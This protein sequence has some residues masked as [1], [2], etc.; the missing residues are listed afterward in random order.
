MFVLAEVVDSIGEDHGDDPEFVGEFVEASCP[1]LGGDEGF[2]GDE[3]AGGFDADVDFGGRGLAFGMAAVK[4]YQFVGEDAAPL[5]LLEAFVHPDRVDAVGPSRRV[6][7]HGDQV[8]VDVAESPKFAPWV[9]HATDC[10]GRCRQY[11]LCGGQ[12]LVADKGV[13]SSESSIKATVCR[14]YSDLV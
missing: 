13:G 12:K 1:A 10:S 11:R 7:G 14:T 8:E 3:P 4:V 2:E 9:I 6:A 5:Y